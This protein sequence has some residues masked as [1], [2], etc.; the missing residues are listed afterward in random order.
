MTK[1]IQRLVSPMFSDNS[2][3][4]VRSTS[5]RSSN[6]T[7]RGTQVPY[8]DENLTIFL[9]PPFDVRMMSFV[10]RHS[11][12]PIRRRDEKKQD[13]KFWRANWGPSKTGQKKNY[14]WKN[15]R[16]RFSCFDWSTILVTF[17][18]HMQERENIRWFGREE[19]YIMKLC[20]QKVSSWQTISR[21]SVSLYTKISVLQIDLFNDVIVPFFLMHH[22]F[23]LKFRDSPKKN[24]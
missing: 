15:F 1:R 2:Q 13:D 9:G 20:E 4:Q 10:W 17:L 3:V 24:A 14:I 8:I 12:R 19:K 5:N 11:N 21:N 18:A 7:I 6:E 16:F 22:L 23:T